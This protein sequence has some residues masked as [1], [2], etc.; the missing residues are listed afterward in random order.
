M[1]EDDD[2]ALTPREQEVLVLKLQGHTDRKIAALLCINETT[3]KKHVQ[4]ILQK[5]PRY[6]RWSE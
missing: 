1:T 3:V 6:R 5:C 4:H 2:K